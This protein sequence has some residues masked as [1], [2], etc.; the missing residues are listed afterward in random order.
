MRRGVVIAAS[1]AYYLASVAQTTCLRFC[2]MPPVKREA[3]CDDETKRLDIWN[4]RK[5]KTCHKRTGMRQT[6]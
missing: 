3:F 2:T 6:L 5:T 4:L 1:S